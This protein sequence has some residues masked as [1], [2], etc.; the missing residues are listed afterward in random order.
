MYTKGEK[1]MEIANSENNNVKVVSFRLDYDSQER[2][3]KRSKEK[4]VSP[5]EYVRQVLYKHLR[6]E[7]EALDL[8]EYVEKRL[9]KVEKMIRVVGLDLV[10]AIQKLLTYSPEKNIKSWI[11]DNM[12]A[13]EWNIKEN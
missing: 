6:N 12:K 11:A 3:L 7:N 9:D 13:I 2:L 4:G 1:N 8:D 10:F 5:H